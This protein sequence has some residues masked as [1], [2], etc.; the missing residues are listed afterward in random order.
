V[1][2]RNG[3]GA[4][5]VD[6]MSTMHTV[7]L[8]VRWFRRLMNPAHFFC[9]ISLQ[10]RLNMSATPTLAFQRQAGQSGIYVSLEL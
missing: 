1:N 4:S 3:W 7:G 5:I 9:R 6:A 2:T 8:D 10:K